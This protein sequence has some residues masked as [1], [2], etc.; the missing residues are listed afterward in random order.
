MRISTRTRLNLIFGIIIAMTLFFGL[1]IVAKSMNQ[2]RLVRLIYAS[3]AASYGVSEAK[4]ALLN[5]MRYSK[6]EDWNS[7]STLLDSSYRSLR[8]AHETCIAVND[9][10]GEGEVQK[11]MAVLSELQQ[12]ERNMKQEIEQNN[13]LL[14][15]VNSVFVVMLETIGR[16]SIIPASLAVGMSRGNDLYQDY[17]AY[18]NLNS[19]KEAYENYHQLALNAI[20]QE[21]GDAIENLAVAEKEMHEGAIALI[22]AKKTLIQHARELSEELGKLS[23]FFSQEYLDDY[24]FVLTSTLVILLSVILFAM[25]ISIYTS[26]LITRSLRQGVEQMELCAAGNFNSHLSREM[27]ERGDEFGNLARAI[28]SMTEQVRGAIGDVK[29]GANNVSVASTQLNEIS[30][31]I[32]E[33]TSTQASSAEEVSSAMEEMAANIDQNAENASQT[34][35]IAL[36]MEEKILKVNELSQKSLGSVASI[37]QK[38]A[39]ITEIANQTNI[40]ALNAA[41]EAARAGEHGRGF[42]VVATE[43]RKLAERS[44]EAATEISTLSSQSLSD[45]QE[46]AR[47]LDD[48]LPEVKHTAQLVLEIATASNEQR[49]GVDQ[50]NSAVQELSGVIQQNASASGEMATAAEDLNT[51]AQ[52]LNSASAFFVIS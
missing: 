19:L 23:G 29:N 15:K 9:K 40:L 48:V 2:R 20:H 42:S 38:I 41:V 21:V 8:M 6:A 43:I 4:I 31:R 28:T 45:T 14:E 51:Q 25:I 1:F 46:A 16:Q 37:T 44:R 47:G 3:D 26:R 39:I 49:Q 17:T 18:D 22:A 34:Q 24:R 50:I 10:T 7:F 11:A 33:G 35:A 52:A 12:D 30:Q 32:S 27:L 13:R 5:Y 36:A